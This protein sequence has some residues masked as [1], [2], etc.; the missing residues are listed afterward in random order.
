[1]PLGKA[2]NMATVARVE[3]GTSLRRTPVIDLAA[4][5]A[6]T[7]IVKAL[8]HLKKPQSDIDI[9][10]VVDNWRQRGMTHKLSPMQR[11]RF[12]MQQGL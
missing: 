6:K 1:M 5:K 7:N 4:F 8:L 9:Y 2:T 3:E 11:T 10:A 12:S